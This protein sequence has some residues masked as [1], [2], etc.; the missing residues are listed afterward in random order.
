[1]PTA[2]TVRTT[3]I[4]QLATVA[5]DRPPRHERAEHADTIAIRLHN[6]ELARTTTSMM[7]GIARSAA[8]HLAQYVEHVGHSGLQL[9]GHAPHANA[10]AQTD[11]TRVPRSRGACIT[12]ARARDGVLCMS[13]MCCYLCASRDAHA[14]YGLRSGLAGVWRGRPADDGHVTVSFDGLQLWPAIQRLKA[15]AG[16]VS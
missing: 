10:R 8:A 16:M 12:H 15:H 3:Q 4:L 2:S 6:G 11:Y 7:I 5:H 14:I 1:M 13:C 9:G